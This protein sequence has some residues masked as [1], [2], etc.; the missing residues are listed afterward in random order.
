MIVNLWRM[1]DMVAPLVMAGLGGLA[2]SGG[3]NL[4]A[5]HTSRALYR[6]QID[7]YKRLDAGY[8]RYLARQ[9]RTYNSARRWERFGRYIA[10]AETN[11]SNSRA[12]S[13]GT[14]GGTFGAGAMLSRRL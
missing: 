5:Q 10:G 11:L 2:L 7:A 1:I 8:S 13:V 9:G 14:F 4:Y 6:R 12:G 3:A